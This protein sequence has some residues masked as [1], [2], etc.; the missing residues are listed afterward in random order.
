KVG[1]ELTFVL[2]EALYALDLI[3]SDLVPGYGERPLRAAMEQ[4]ML[5]APG[6]WNRHYSGDAATEAVLRHYSL[7]DRIRYYWASEAAE[8]AVARLMEALKG[9]TVPLPLMWQ[10]LPAAT[11]FADRP[12]DPEAL[13][14]WRVGES[15]RAYH[16]ACAL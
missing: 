5:E 4:V 3:A 6:N 11:A 9:Q 14:I 12:L 8:A 1:P 10:H 15:L 16:A 13:L 2:R 7:S